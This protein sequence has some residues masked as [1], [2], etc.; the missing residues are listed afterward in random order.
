MA[1]VSVKV[2]IDQK[3]LEHAVNFSEG[4]ARALGAKTDAIT[5]AANGM[6]A[7]FRTGRYHR[8]H[9]SPA[10]GDTPASYAGNVQMES[11]GYVGIVYTANYAAQKDNY[12]NNTLLKAKG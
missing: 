2:V 3:A 9:R 11:K 1:S 10:V 5:G 12:L 7:G 8:D 6:S 4:T